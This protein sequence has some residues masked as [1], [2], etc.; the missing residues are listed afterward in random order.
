MPFGNPSVIPFLLFPDIDECAN[1]GRNECDTNAECSN[2][3]GSYTCTCLPGYQGDGKSCPGNTPSLSFL[4]G[5]ISLPLSAYT[6]SEWYANI[7]V[8]KLWFLE[9]Y[10]FLLTDLATGAGIIIDIVI[11][12]LFVHAIEFAF[13]FTRCEWMSCRQ[14]RL[15]ADMYQH[16]RRLQLFM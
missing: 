15:P 5:L 12:V 10:D 9:T 6:V 2:T 13:I 14:W 3:E 7:P 16:Q 8:I 1:P 11:I 4:D